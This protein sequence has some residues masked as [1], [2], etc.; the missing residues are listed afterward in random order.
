MRSPQLQCVHWRPSLPRFLRKLSPK[1]AGGF[2]SVRC[3]VSPPAGHPT[4][5]RL[6][7]ATKKMRRCFQ[8]LW[9][10]FRR[11]AGRAGGRHVVR[12]S[13]DPPHPPSRWRLLH[14]Q[15]QGRSQCH[16]LLMA[17]SFDDLTGSSISK[18][19]SPSA[20]HTASMQM[21]L[22]EEET[23]KYFGSKLV[24]RSRRLSQSV[25]ISR[26]ATHTRKV[27]DKKGNKK[28]AF[29]RRKSRRK[30]A[31]RTRRTSR[32]TIEQ[33]QG[34]VDGLID[35]VV[36]SSTRLIAQRQSELEQCQ[37]VGRGMLQ[38]SSQLQRVS[39]KAVHRPHWRN[40]SAICWW[41]C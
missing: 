25:S 12:E 11:D 9:P 27:A 37:E 28:Y 41:C 30:P 18:G 24:L 8:K 31:K 6:E 33:L 39:K 21:D 17:P 35:A 26:P 40:A 1:A 2:S 36:D 19:L 15:D 3:L 32:L 5:L 38:S 29:W 34:Q 20:Q 16:R 23:Q 7:D 10:P 22:V 4:A 13:P 14:P